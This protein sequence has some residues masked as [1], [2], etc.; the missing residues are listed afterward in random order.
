MMKRDR[1]N[2]MT[3][4]GRATEWWRRVG[5][6]VNAVRASVRDVLARAK[7]AKPPEGVR[8]IDGGILHGSISSIGQGR[9]RE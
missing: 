3:R 2:R 5:S 7:Y 4:G 8:Y 1:S 9:G 6:E